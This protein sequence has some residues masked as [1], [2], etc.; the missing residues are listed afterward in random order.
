MVA[1]VYET[2]NK[3][4]ILFDD[5][6]E[7][8]DVKD[9]RKLLV[10]CRKFDISVLTKDVSYVFKI[11]KDK[12]YL[13]KLKREYTYLKRYS[14]VE[15]RM[16]EDGL[17]MKYIGKDLTV[18]L[19]KSTNI[20]RNFFSR[21]I[22]RMLDGFLHGDIKLENIVLNNKTK[23]LDLIDYEM[24]DINIR[25]KYNMFFWNR[26][27]IYLLG[28]DGYNFPLYKGNS[29]LSWYQGIINAMYSLALCYFIHGYE[30]EITY[31]DE[32]GI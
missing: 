7:L 16:L 11:G 25:L 19:V 3:Y 8:K 10:N 15:S 32:L 14:T 2:T 24:V 12:D 18:A 6:R 21:E 1:Y 22:S 27:K 4:V 9:V 30:N 17:L 31:F 5:E 13:S 20:W 26:R 23:K 28:T 29:T